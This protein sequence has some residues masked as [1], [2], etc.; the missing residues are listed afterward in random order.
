MINTHEVKRISSDLG[1]MNA[2]PDSI[3]RSVAK[4]EL[5]L[6]RR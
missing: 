1:T 6:K 5:Y 2:C 3:K 4:I